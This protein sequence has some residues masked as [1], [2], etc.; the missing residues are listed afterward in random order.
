MAELLSTDQ[1]AQNWIADANLFFTSNT[2]VG[3][4]GLDGHGGGLRFR[5]NHPVVYNAAH[6]GYSHSADFDVSAWN[7]DFTLPLVVRADN[8]RTITEIP[9]DD[10]AYNQAPRFLGK[11]ISEPGALALGAAFRYVYEK[12]WYDL[13]KHKCLVQARQHKNLRVKEVDDPRLASLAFDLALREVNLN[14][15]QY[16]VRNRVDDIGREQ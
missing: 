13:Q 8:N 7:L 14:Q 11:T 2:P 3:V 10:F 1:M 5:F 4:G 15:L 9:I 6:A 12:R 16:A